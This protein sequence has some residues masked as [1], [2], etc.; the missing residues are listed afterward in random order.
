VL[1]GTLWLWIAATAFAANVS[2]NP[3][4]TQNVE[5]NLELRGHI[6]AE[7]GRARNIQVTLFGVESP[8]RDTVESDHGGNF[9]FRGLAPGNYTVALLR[10]GLGEVRRTVV[11]SAALADK[12]GVVKATIPWAPAEAVNNGGGAVSAQRLMVPEDAEAKY[13]EAK[14]RLAQHD[15]QGAV[16][17]LQAAVLLAPRFAAAWNSLGV[18]AFQSGDDDQAEKYFEK[19]LSAEPDSFEPLVNLGGVM[20]K[21]G[22]N[23]EALRYN[24]RAVAEHPLDALA[25]AQLG[26]SYF[27]LHDYDQAEQ[28][29]TAAKKQDPALFTQPQ[30]FLAEIY[31]R[32]GDRAS[33]IRE[34]QELLA[35]RPDGPM[36]QRVQRSLESLQKR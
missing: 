25:N 14:E 5:P 19:S 30:L 21:E 8:Y 17:S 13:A 33:A 22:R 1:R 4:A 18:I 27:Q 35:Q 11:V 20:L 16:Q 36:A 12:H 26:M 9:R 10:E 31:A 34:L 2:T 24:Q 6:E 23:Q 29:L 7:A 32:R 28:Y 3:P 15:T